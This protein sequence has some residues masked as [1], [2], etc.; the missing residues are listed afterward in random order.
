VGNLWLALNYGLLSASQ[1]A[2]G[3]AS[4]LEVCAA[5]ERNAHDERATTSQ[6]GHAKSLIG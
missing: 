2:A 1:A 4:A 6:F 3:H 5:R